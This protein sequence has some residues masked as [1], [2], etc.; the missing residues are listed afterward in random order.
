MV[1]SYLK[2]PVIFS[3]LTYPIE[4]SPMFAQDIDNHE[5][6]EIAEFKYKFLKEAENQNLKK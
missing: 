5:D 6:W 3:D 2:D 4:L 1:K